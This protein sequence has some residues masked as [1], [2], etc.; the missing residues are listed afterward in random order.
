MLKIQTILHPTDFSVN[1]RAAWELA[2]TLAHDY[3]ARLVLL[4]VHAIPVAVY[5]E[6][7]TLPPR[8]FDPEALKNELAQ[9]QPTYPGLTVERT[10]IEGSPGRDIVAFATESKCDLIVMGTHGRTGLGRLLMGSVAEEAVRRAPCPVLT[11]KT[12]MPEAGSKAS[13]AETVA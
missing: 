13:K 11:V 5:G 7:G 8:P 9:V 6:F 2:C 4:H 10:A 1:S 12:P 3:Q